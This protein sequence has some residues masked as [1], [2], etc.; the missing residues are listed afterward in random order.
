M[1]AVELP[2]LAVLVVNY[3]SHQLLEQHLAPLVEAARKSFAVVVDNHTTHE[4]RC[5]VRALSERYGWHLETPAENLG[6]G[7]GMN[8]AASTALS[9]G[10]E[11]LLL[12]NPDVRLE[13]HTLLQL[14]REVVKHPSALVSPMLLRPDGSVFFH[15]TDL[16]LDSGR[17][18]S[19]RRRPA[20]SCTNGGPRVRPWLS[21]ACLLLDKT[22]WSTAGGFDDDYFLYWEDVDFS[23]RVKC[24]G[25]ELRVLSEAVALHDEGATSR[26][27]QVS[28][29]A[30]SDTY[31]YYNIRNRLLYARKHL[32]RATS[33]RWAV[34][35]PLV[36]AEILLQGGRKQFLHSLRPALTAVRATRDGLLLL[37]G[38]RHPGGRRG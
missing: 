11:H 12:L 37:A 19:R 36:A 2:R 32:D 35:S 21:G 5:A 33:L 1:T 16:Y 20:R 38:L 6:F 25:G 4:E 31:Y 34:L 9:L 3:G 18:R 27:E 26:T 13:E 14:R 24:S 29:R 7:A 15:G 22:L 8:L 10:A 23:H 30:R 28:A 17:M